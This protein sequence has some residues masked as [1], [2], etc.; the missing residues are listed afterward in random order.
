M[1]PSSQTF[2]TT[3][4]T[5]YQKL[6]DIFFLFYNQPT[7]DFVTSTFTMALIG[8][9]NMIYNEDKTV[10]AGYTRL[11]YK[12]ALHRT[13]LLGTMADIRNDFD[14]QDENLVDIKTQEDQYR[15]RVFNFIDDILNDFRCVGKMNMP[16]ERAWAWLIHTA[17]EGPWPEHVTRRLF[18]PEHE[19]CLSFLHALESIVIQRCYDRKRRGFRRVP[20]DWI[21]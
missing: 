19:R 15:L 10:R 14:K 18:A 20:I 21:R 11:P 2:D 7:F 16:S 4:D 6:L 3:T 8:V 5:T 9:N 17:R 13:G 1:V 12:V